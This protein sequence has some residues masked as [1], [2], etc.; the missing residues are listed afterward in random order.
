MR[1]PNGNLTLV[2]HPEEP[3][4]VLN[5][6]RK[7]AMVV[8]SLVAVV[9]LT[10]RITF[11]MNLISP[12]AVFASVLLL[13]GEAYGIFTMVLFFM[14]VWDVSEPPR[15]PVLPDRTVDVLVP[16]YNE[17]AQLLR[18]TLQACLR[19]DYP[20]RTYL[21]DDKRR[22]DIQALA[23][24]LGVHYITRADNSHAKAGN[25]NNA[26][27]QTD[28]EFVIIFDADHV[29]EKHFITRLIGYFAD[30][31]L[32]F[33]QTPHAF[34]NF[35]SFQASH[36]DNKK[37]YWEE[38]AMFYGLIQPGKNRFGCPIFAGS[39][40]MFRRS[41]LAEVGYIATETITEDMHTGMRINARGWKSLAITERLIAGQA[42][43]DVTTFHSQ[44]LR[45]AKGNLSIMWVNFPLTMRGLSL[46]QRMSHFASCVHWLGGL[47]RLPLYLTPV[48]FLFS[49]VPPVANYTW[50]LLALTALY[51]LLMWAAVSAAS[52]G[53][54]SFW[55]SELFDMMS[56]WTKSR[57][58]VQAL[59]VGTGGKFVVTSKR[60]RQSKSV[61]PLLRPH[62]LL[63]VVTVLALAW[64]WG[65]VMMGLS[66]DWGKLLLAT[67]WALFYMSLAAVVIRRALAPDDARYDYRHPVNLGLTYAVE[68]PLTSARG[69]ALGGAP[70]PARLGLTVD[71]SE[72][73]LGLLTYE[74][75]EPGALLKIQLHGAG[76]ELHCHGR[77]SWTS[78]LFRSEGL[79]FQGCRT[80]VM[81]E[82]LTPEQVD[83]LQHLG[84]H[85]AV[86]RQ[87]HDLA[88]GTA[89]AGAG[90]I[91]TQAQELSRGLEGRCFEFH[92]PLEL[93]LLA[94]AA[95][96]DYCCTE[97]VAKTGMKVLLPEPLATGGRYKFHMGTPLGDVRGEACVS[98]NDLLQL[99]GRSYYLCTLTFAEL[100]AQD[101][102]LL[103]SL[104]DPAEHRAP[105]LTVLKP[106][107]KQ[108]RLPVLKP[109]AVAAALLL[110]LLVGQVFA[111]SFFCSDDIRLRDIALEQTVRAG[112]KDELLKI[113]D[114]TDAMKHPSTDRLVLL[115]QA[116]KRLGD[117]AQVDRLT[118]KLGE[119]DPNNIELQIALFDTHVKNRQI[120][121]M[122][123]VHE[124][125]TGLLDYRFQPVVRQ[126][127]MLLVAA[128]ACVHAGRYAV[129]ARYFDAALDMAKEDGTVRKE[130]AGVLLR[131]GRADEVIAMY[132]A[133]VKSPPEHFLVAA[134]HRMK[135]NYEAAERE[136]QLALKEQ[137]EYVP[138]RLLLADTLRAS[139][140]IK[141]SKEAYKRVAAVDPF[142]ELLQMRVAYDTLEGSNYLKALG[143]LRPLVSADVRRAD[144]VHAFIDAA[145]G[146]ETMPKE[147]RALLVR[148]Y[149]TVDRGDKDNRVFVD[150][151]SWVLQRVGEYERSASLLK[152]LIG[153]NGKNRNY[154]LRYANCLFALD[155]PAEA[156]A[157]LTPLG[158]D[159]EALRLIAGVSLNKGDTAEA[160][161]ACRAMLE[162]KPD[163]PDTLNLLAVT[164]ATRK[165]YKEA[166]QVYTKLAGLRPKDQEVR[167]RLA[168]L[169]V[170]AQDYPTAVARYEGLLAGKLEQPRL[171]EGFV[172]AAAGCKGDLTDGQKELAL[173]LAAAFQNSKDVGAANM[174]RLGY[175]LTRAKA[176]PAV[177][178][179]LLRA[180][181]AKAPAEEAVRKELAGVLASAGM[182]EE[183]LKMYEGLKLTF[184]EQRQ[185]IG[186]RL[187]AR[188]YDV[189]EALT[190]KLLRERPDDMALQRYLGDVL[191]AGKRFDEAA[192]VYE[193]VLEAHPEDGRLR[194]GLA[195]VYLG[196]KRYNEALALY[197]KVLEVDP[198][199]TKHYLGYIDAAASARAL[200]PGEDGPV[201][202]R[203]VRWARQEGG[204]KPVVLKR[205]TWV[206]Q[207]LKNRE[208]AVSL[209]RLSMKL[210]PKDSKLLFELADTLYEMGRFKEA[211]SHYLLATRG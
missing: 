58:A 21:L 84:T 165:K 95:R 68:T 175:V 90:L 89:R 166:D 210:D 51:L 19:M 32:A 100:P 52:G 129:A 120:D 47:F 91:N 6:L 63:V 131:E 188:Q 209:I 140:R 144:L 62:L 118:E 16:T 197:R 161:K 133:E 106:R 114:E 50:G 143:L 81:L 192:G 87:Y 150:R 40:A 38:G 208:A 199:A 196:G 85:Y 49:G 23:E 169:S 97:V 157:A 178:Q 158:N 12:Y 176:P 167:E 151:L 147:D 17:D 48:L 135:N 99:G 28:G 72:R 204:D 10:L 34:Y 198:G 177:V 134:A 60:G 103:N 67:L 73:G 130:Y 163:D 80:G 138:A 46:G 202:G 200:N 101:R 187:S 185:L 22:P 205:L 168:E 190:R 105:L 111:F 186:V 193:K 182:S 77:V 61:W 54:F 1:P 65:R 194:A 30:E 5:I 189:A 79:P 203:L 109:V 112:E 174:T 125:V 64:G 74:P 201:V 126:R 116:W 43:P 181:A 207:R 110:P 88:L 180:A 145:A 36:D 39:A 37:T 55:N 70:A 86:S 57:A 98:R 146:V 83:V 171:W 104:V 31:K 159:P 117:D 29:P 69:A 173:K 128:R 75:L 141:E 44:R 41:A 102:D 184:E 76:E 124:H 179:S 71:V 14:Q 149:D 53:R 24:E 35:D 93:E 139:G 92:L 25:L 113:T 160:E 137:P 96:K 142:N 148:I 13:V 66:A 115:R 132:G 56:F 108:R 18:A 2:T 153:E 195:G 3:C 162:S 45:W 11:T 119:R 82:D 27:R 59:L 42:A 183:S 121:K 94:E 172:N 107:R 127:S 26:L 4:V 7:P 9:Y 156:R 206:C 164:L 191:A 155:R 122:L 136:C 154:R 20:H 170:W 8:A 211:E 123:D 152:L 33:V 15:R 78:E